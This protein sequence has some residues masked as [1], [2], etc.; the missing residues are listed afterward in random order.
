M[1]TA[2]KAKRSARQSK[3][4]SRRFPKLSSAKKK[5]VADFLKSPLFGMW[6][7]YPGTV[8]DYMREVRKPR[9]SS[10]FGNDPLR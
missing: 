1:S 10:V 7:D 5:R 3:V 9:F 6:K 4:A 2:V 8:E